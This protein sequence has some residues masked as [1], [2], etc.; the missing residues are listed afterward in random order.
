MNDRVL[1]VDD[2]K[3]CRNNIKRYLQNKYQV[4]TAASLE[5]ALDLL[6]NSGPYQMVITDIGLS[7]DETG[8]EGIDLLRAINKHWPTTMTIAISGRAAVVN[9]DKF[10]EEYHTLDYLPRDTLDKDKIIALVERGVALSHEAE[11]KQS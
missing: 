2:T 1:V 8:T 10:R 11:G 4:D 9:V 6:T 7:P 3:I 5:E